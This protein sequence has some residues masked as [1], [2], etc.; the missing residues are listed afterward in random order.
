MSVSCGTWVPRAITS[1]S[2]CTLRVTKLCDIL[3]MSSQQGIFLHRTSGGRMSR[4]DPA[5]IALQVLIINKCRFGNRVR[6]LQPQ[7]ATPLGTEEQRVLYTFAYIS[8]FIY[9]YMNKWISTL[10]VFYINIF[11]YF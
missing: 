6:R 5:R 9:Q 2:S 7:V 1:S 4:S 11:Y 3:H 8:A 10:L